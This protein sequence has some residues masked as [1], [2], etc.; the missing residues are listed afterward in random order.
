M[1]P[2]TPVVL[3]TSKVIFCS[4]KASMA[5]DINVMLGAVPLS[6]IPIC[7]PLAMAS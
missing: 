5:P 6:T 7:S 3:M 4:A 1:S 2:P